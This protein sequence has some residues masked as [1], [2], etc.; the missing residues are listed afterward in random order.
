MIISNFLSR[1]GSSDLNETLKLCITLHFYHLIGIIIGH[2]KPVVQQ[3]PRIALPAIGIKHLRAPLNIL[4]GLN[5]KATLL[6]RIIPGSVLGHPMVQHISKG[7]QRIRLHPVN[8]KPE[9]TAADGRPSPAELHEGVVE[10]KVDLT[11]KVEVF[12]QVRHLLLY[13]VQ[14]TGALQLAQLRLFV[15]NRERF[16]AARKDLD[17]VFPEGVGFGFLVE[18]EQRQVCVLWGNQLHTALQQFP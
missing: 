11:A 18:Q 9:Y 8:H 10:V 7:H 13:H 15:E 3:K 5:H 2:Y 4:N 17:V 12:A 14:E 1:S 6:L 16:V